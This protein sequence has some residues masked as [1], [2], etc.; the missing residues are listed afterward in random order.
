MKKLLPILGMVII[1]A[2]VYMGVRYISTMIHYACLNPVE[3]CPPPFRGLAEIGYYGT[4][5]SLIPVFDAKFERL[6]SAPLKE[7]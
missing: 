7:Q 1:V 2:G 4:G 3:D 5:G 6:Q